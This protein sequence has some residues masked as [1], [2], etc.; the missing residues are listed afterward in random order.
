ML[1]ALELALPPPILVL[2]VA[3]PLPVLVVAL[4]VVF[5]LLLHGNAVMYSNSAVAAVTDR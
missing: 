4:D 2:L 5:A 1:Q 3:L